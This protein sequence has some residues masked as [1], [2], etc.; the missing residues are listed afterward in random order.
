MGY[1]STIHV[2]V[3]IKEGC[4]AEARKAVETAIK[5]KKLCYYEDI[6]LGDDGDIYFDEYYGKHY[7]TETLAILA[8]FVEEGQF[9]FVGE[10]DAVWAIEFDGKGNWREKDGVMAPEW[11]RTTDW[12]NAKIELAKKV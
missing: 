10:D 4:I 12:T 2:E 3:T 5:S 9:W 1:E 7:E 11:E 6:R 8:P